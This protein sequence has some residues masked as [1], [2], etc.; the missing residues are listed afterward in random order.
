[1]EKDVLE[2]AVAKHAGGRPTT[3]GIDHPCWMTM[4]EDI[5]QGK[6]LSTA[7][8]ADGMPSY[9]LVMAMIKKDVAF[10]AMYEKAIEDRADRLAE[11]ILELA[12][13]AIPANLDGPSKSAWVQQKRLQV[14]TRKWVAAKL[15]PKVYGDRIDVSVTDTRISVSDALKEAKQRVLTD[16]SNIVDVAV[17]EMAS[18]E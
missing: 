4:C 5:S 11:E 7:L 17:K 12:D 16:E 8:K 13:E 2:M 3:F 14:D 1:M 15:K 10:R 9:V 18:K 6:S